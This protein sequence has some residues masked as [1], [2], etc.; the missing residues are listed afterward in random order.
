MADMSASSPQAERARDPWVS[1]RVI[2][3]YIYYFHMNLEKL[4][5]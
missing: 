3:F 1:K 5:C 4:K 2:L